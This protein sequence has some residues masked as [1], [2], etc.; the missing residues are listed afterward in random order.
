M[1]DD[2]IPPDASEKSR[3]IALTLAGTLG[4]FGA[5]RFYAGRKGT[6]ILMAMT[7]GG[8]GMWYLYDLILVAFGSFRDA[9]GRRITEWVEGDPMDARELMTPAMAREIM[10][11]L[12]NLR[13]EV[14]DL[15]ERVEFAERLLSKGTVREG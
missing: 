9:N 3:A 11:E 1:A 5:H 7:L 14:G 10:D 8:C 2:L 13:E 6:G 12:Y 4:I 15:G